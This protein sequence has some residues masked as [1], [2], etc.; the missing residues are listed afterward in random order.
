MNAGPLRWGVL[1]TASIALRKVIPAL[2]AS[3]IND[4]VA[5]ASRD[6]ARAEHAA[7]AAGVGR[8]FGSYQDLL[9][10]TSIDAVYVPLPNHLH[11]PWSVKALEAG[12]HVLCEKPLGLN[13]NDARVVYHAAALHPGLTVMEAFMYRSHP[14]WKQVRQLVVDG[15][16]GDL[17]CVHTIFSYD[18]RNPGDIRNIAEIG[19]GA[20]LD[21]GCYGVSTARFLFGAE[22]I[23]LVAHMELDPVF[24][25]DRLTSAVLDFG[26]GSATVTCATQLAPHQAV[27]IH[28]STGRIEL[29]LPFNAPAETAT[30][31]RL[32]RDG[33]VHEIMVE[34][35]DQFR[36]QAD[37][38]ADAVLRG[39]APPVSLEDSLANMV[40]LDKARPQPSTG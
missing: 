1:G 14:R 9:D 13:A 15:V 36:A 40:A 21:I 27:S 11:V 23:A 31:I 39:A 2:H 10:D 6:Q 29:E 28:G 20:W 7:K 22:P 3:S 8:A 25:T 32:Y 33:A 5:I 35:C 24:G 4:V 37:C 34:P 38:F 12:K 17:G 19:G 18:N 16:V 26:R 30:S